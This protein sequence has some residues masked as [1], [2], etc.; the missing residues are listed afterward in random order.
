MRR[1]FAK[2]LTWIGALTVFLGVLIVLGVMLSRSNTGRIPASTVLEVNLETPLAEDAPDDPLA[3][4]T[5]RAAHS[6]RDIVEAL[7]KA[8]DDARV[9]GMIART[10]SAPMSIAQIQ[11]IRD[12]V[13]AFRAKKKFA[14]CYSE[15]FGEFGQGNGSY[16]LATAFDEIWMQPSGEV[17]LNGIMLQAMFLRGTFDKVGIVP[18]FDQ[19]YEYKNAVNTYTDKKMNEPF[20]EAMQ[21]LTDS[22]YGQL[23]RGIAQSRKMTEEQAK[24]VLGKGPYHGA[25]ALDTKLVDGVAYRDEVYEKVKARAGAGSEMLYLDK[26]LE[27]AGR[28]HQKG[29]RVALIF[30]VGGVQR[31]KSNSDPFGGSS[32]MGSDTVAGAFRQAIRDKDVKAIL[33]RVDSPGGSYVASDTIWRETLNAKKAGKPVI[34]SMASL[35]ASG[36]YFVSM[37]ADKIV[38]Q[39]ATITGSIGVFGG[40]FLANGLFD[41]LGLSFDDVSR[42]ENAHMLSQVHDFSPQEW[43]RFQDWLNRI[44]GDFTTKVA[45]GRK[46]PKEKVL[47]IAKGR[48]WSGEDARGLGLVDEVGG[49]PVALKLVKQAIKLKDSDDIELRVYPKQKTA[50][51]TLMARLQGD[52]GDSSESQQA[53]VLA[54]TLEAVR[55]AM[56][57]LRQAGVIGPRQDVL[58]LPPM[59][60][61]H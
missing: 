9:K 39:P 38:A 60:L 40:K 48:V 16:Y 47:Q 12:A 27:R 22:V 11:E 10:G 51:E 26:Y 46:L 57:A 18:R 4:L 21:K 24:A 33:F 5:G 50:I 43:E 37:A 55:P 8:G 19:R 53:E 45:E 6:V 58:S 28:P 49:Y 3:K 32:A 35:A 7:D 23:G 15:S 29:P 54:R 17:G 41:K 2:I 1:F 59:N 56:Q 30:G 34:V 14:V 52:E 44:Y 31:G 13:Q 20:R 25:E 42:G 61:I 36:G